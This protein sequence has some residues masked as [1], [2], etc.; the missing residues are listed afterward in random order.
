MNVSS[1][2]ACEIAKK[3]SGQDNA[4]REILVTR[5]IAGIV[6][7]FT[8]IMNVFVS[9]WSGLMW[10]DGDGARR[11]ES[12]SMEE[13]PLPGQSLGNISAELQWCH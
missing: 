6:S 7:V 8:V 13:F 2:W 3:V 11:A 4:F 5:G 10:S 12:G 1:V 9:Q